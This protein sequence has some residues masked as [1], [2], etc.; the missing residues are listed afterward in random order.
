MM[1]SSRLERVFLSASCDPAEIV[2]I[3][4]GFMMVQRK[5][6]LLLVAFSDAV[7]WKAAANGFCGI[8]DGIVDIQAGSN[9]IPARVE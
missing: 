7:L 4:P 1:T 3:C 9:P 2:L 8:G 6:W 5:R